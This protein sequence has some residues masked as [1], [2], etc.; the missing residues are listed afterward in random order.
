MSNFYLDVLQ[1]HPKFTSA[2]RICNPE[3][4]EPNFRRKV[5]RILEEARAHGLELMV[6][7]TYRSKQR[8]Q[9][10]FAAGATKLK[11]VGVHH[12]GLACDLVRC[13]NGQPSWGGDFRL[14]GHLARSHDL[15]W[16]GDWT[17]FPDPCHVQWCA[18][19]DQP[20]LFR[21]TW[22]PSPDYIP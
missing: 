15:V 5:L 22:Y 8:Q 11:T 4:L 6:F 18:V 1:H 21:G 9:R 2:E 20:K 10:L 12:F 7:E 14:L 16:G 13:V 17:T 19:K 3:M